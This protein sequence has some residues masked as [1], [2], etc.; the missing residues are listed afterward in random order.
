MRF[1]VIVRPKFPIPPEQVGMVIE[2]FA[3]WR[4]RYRDHFEVFEFFAGQGGGFGIVD[5][6]DAESF[7]QMMFENPV[8]F[9]ADVEVHP[10]LDGDVGIKQWR[11][12]TARMMAG[13]PA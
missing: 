13:A 8:N 10:T 11:E 5:F 4:E 7:N 1:A 3:Q 2:G 6:P 12:T 9:F